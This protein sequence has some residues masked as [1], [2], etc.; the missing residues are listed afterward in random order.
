MLVQ[1]VVE[2]TIAAIQTI[3]NAIIQ[4]TYANVYVWSTTKLVYLVLSS[5]DEPEIWAVFL[6]LSLPSI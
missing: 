1:I 2:E 4:A 3:N 6:L 5:L